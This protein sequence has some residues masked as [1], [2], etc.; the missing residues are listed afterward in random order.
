MTR[1]IVVRRR[2]RCR[3]LERRRFPGIVGR[4]LALEHAPEEIEVEQDL[5]QHCDYRCHSDEY[6]QG[7]RMLQKLVF[8][9][10]RVAPRHSQH[11]HRV[12]R[13]KD[14]VHAEKGNPK[15]NLAQALAHHA[16]EHFRKPEVSRGE[17]S[18]D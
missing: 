15:M 3:P 4:L 13:N 5:N 11:S 17:H 16:A 6:D 14:R 8:A 7:V 18:K 10:L 1:E 9:K 12:K 2:S